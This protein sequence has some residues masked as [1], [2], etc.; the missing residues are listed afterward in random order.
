MPRTGSKANTLPA[1]SRRFPAFPPSQQPGRSRAPGLGGEAAN[2]PTD[3]L[4]DLE[5]TLP[6]TG[7]TGILGWSRFQ[8]F[9]PPP[10]LGHGG[11]IM[12]G[13]GVR[14]PADPNDHD[15]QFEQ[16]APLYDAGGMT[17]FY[18][19]TSDMPANNEGLTASG[20]LSYIRRK[21]DTTN[22]GTKPPDM[23]RWGDPPFPRAYRQLRFTLRREFMQNAQAFLGQHTRMIKQGRASTSPVRMRAPRTSRLTNRAPTGSFGQQTEVLNG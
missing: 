5:E 21:V 7:F 3:D 6:E 1:R 19:R 23:I 22:A 13:S 9:L 15:S 20:R 16:Q 4:G 11:F 12:G 10:V 18:T 17:P 14:P 2:L 8:S